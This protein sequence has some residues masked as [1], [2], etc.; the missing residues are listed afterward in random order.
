MKGLDDMV[1]KI[2]VKGNMPDGLLIYIDYDVMYDLFKVEQDLLG[3]G[4]GA[5]GMSVLSA[6]LYVHEYPDADR[7]WWISENIWKAVK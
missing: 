4:L 3:K 2:T 7:P 1:R 5:L 6:M